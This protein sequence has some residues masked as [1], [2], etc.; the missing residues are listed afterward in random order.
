MQ[1]VIQTAVHW[2]QGSL[3]CWLSLLLLSGLL[4]T[5]CGL[6]GGGGNGG[7][8]GGDTTPP[9]PPS[10][11]SATSQDGAIAL[12]WSPTSAGDLAGYSVYRSTASGVDATGSPLASGLS[13][14]E[15]VDDTAENGATYYYVVT[16]V[17]EADNESDSSGEV[18]KTP[19]SK[20]PDRP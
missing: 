14:A 18:E 20:P 1:T 10:G 19:F 13:S 15:Y 5:G 3:N 8:N 11:L 7:D 16:A 17:D 12:D 6:F 4:L 2:P 9:N